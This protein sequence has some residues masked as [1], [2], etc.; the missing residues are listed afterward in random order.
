MIKLTEKQL[1][2]NLI[3]TILLD[4]DK[5]DLVEAYNHLRLDK[6]TVEEVAWDG[7]Y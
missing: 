7:E 5:D 6:I 3:S 1:L 4:L 2:N